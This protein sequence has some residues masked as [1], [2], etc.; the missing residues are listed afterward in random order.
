MKRS[1]IA[2]AAWFWTALALNPASTIA[3]TP[4]A[5]KLP[6]IFD[7]M[8]KG[9]V[10]EMEL[11]TDLTQL[12]AQKKT[13]EYQTAT[14]SYADASGQ[15]KSWNVKIRSR[16]KFRRRICAFPPLKLNFNKTELQKA[17]LSKDDEIKLITHCVEG[18]EGKEFLVR[19]Y[20]IYKLYQILSPAAYR[21]QLAQIKYRDPKNSQKINAWGIL[22]EDESSLA[23]RMG[24][25]F[26]DDC[27]SSPL[28]SFN[29]KQAH[30]AT[31][32]EYMIA[33][34]DWSIMMVRNIKMLKFKDGR[35]AELVPYDFDFSG[36]VNASYAV[37]DVNFKL[38]S[39]RDRIYLGQAKTDAE[40]AETFELF[41]S[42][43]QEMIDAIKACKSL[44]ALGRSDMVTFM[45]GFFEAIKQP[46]RRP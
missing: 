8:A 24:G 22:M 4:Q 26:C 43:R 3:Q 19:E 18:P 33:N 28:D 37:P 12:K 1:V 17:G 45:D 30:I 7:D 32:F 44:S 10:L 6:S 5:A 39:V 14:L 29:L 41:K 9:E 20:L 16:G 25:K 42:K 36:M 2:C 23:K 21:V 34:T 13:N 31:L 35:K 40:L 11:N 38:Q 46:L 15:S 27:Y